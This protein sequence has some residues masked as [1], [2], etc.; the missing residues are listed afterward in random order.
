MSEEV[1]R[2]K[3]CGCELMS[4][5]KSKYC[6][7]HKRERSNFIANIGKG[8]VALGGLIITI[9]SLVFKKDK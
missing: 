7:K 2:C 6:E 3:K 9:G 8:A 1:R 4:N 5:N